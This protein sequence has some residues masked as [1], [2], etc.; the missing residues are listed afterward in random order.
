MKLHKAMF[1]PSHA[2]LLIAMLLPA[3]AMAALTADEVAQTRKDKDSGWGST[4]SMMEMTLRNAQGDESTRKL[5]VKTLE[6]KGEGDQSITVFE[7]PFDIRGTSLL[8]HSKIE[9]SDD[10]WLYL[11]AL[12]RVK[13]ISSANKS[14]PFVGSEF[15]YEDLS[16]F[17]VAKYD[18]KL[19]PDA[20]C[21]ELT[22]YVLEATPRYEF[23][24]YTKLVN[25][26][27]KEAFRLQKVEF[28]D[29]RNALLKTLTLDD[30]R[31]YEDKF[32][33]AH[34]M[35]MV[36]EQTGKSTVLTVEDI[37]FSPSFRA[38]EFRQAQF[39]RSVKR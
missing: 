5:E 34:V 22:C 12:K 3:T 39:S 24:G 14:G 19:L 13:R 26:I 21:G 20:P 6:R 32:W 33:R 11:P 29:R 4:L 18:Y 37:D 15:A 25:W 30:Y 16:S 36:N 1:K 27:D 8:V 38:G 35:D 17:E 10:Q 23:T 9:D 2:A 31:L 28:Y 7:E